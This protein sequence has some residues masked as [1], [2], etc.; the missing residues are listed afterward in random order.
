MHD[1]H[2]Y[3]FFSHSGALFAASLP[4]SNLYYSPW[5]PRFRKGYN[6]YIL[7]Q[8]IEAEKD[9]LCQERVVLSLSHFQIQSV[10]QAFN[11]PLMNCVLFSFL[12]AYVC[13]YQATSIT[14]DQHP[15]YK[16]FSNC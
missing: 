9:Y 4:K 10:S 7:T 3:H 13:I 12:F 8:E 11:T 1:F 16:G 15:S 5:K 14:S 2:Q 6:P